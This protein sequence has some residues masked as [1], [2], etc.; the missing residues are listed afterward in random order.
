MGVTSEVEKS[1]E[2]NSKKSDDGGGD[3]NPCQVQGKV[4][5]NHK[6]NSAV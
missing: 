5:T 4:S 6:W 2:L 3:G 1:E